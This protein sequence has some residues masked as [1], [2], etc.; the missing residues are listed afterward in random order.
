MPQTDAVQTPNE[1]SAPQTNA[2]YEL[3][4]LCI[5]VLSLLILLASILPFIPDRFRQLLR[6]LDIAFSLA[7][8]VDFAH[9][10]WRAPDRW[11]YFKRWGWLD[12]LGSIPYPPILHVARIARIVRSVRNLRVTRPESVAQDVSEHRGQASVLLVLFVAILVVVGASLLVLDVEDRQPEGRIHGAGDALWWAIV[13]I[14]T[15]GYGDEYPV[16]GLGRIAAVVVMVVGIALWGVLAS[17]LASTFMRPVRRELDDD[18]AAI[19]DQVN[20][21]AESL[22][23]LEQKLDEPRSDEGNVSR[24]KLGP[25]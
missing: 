20:R 9:S 22:D 17:T 18:V 4:M 21:M 10:L 8:L 13:T 2:A 16:S 15:V 25:K 1:R 19:R 24:R 6:I 23:R 5:A 14:T 12:L 11:T 3:F 7:F